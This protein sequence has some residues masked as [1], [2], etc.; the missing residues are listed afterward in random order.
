[1]SAPTCLAS[2]FR[3]LGL[4]P[5]LIVALTFRARSM[6]EF[7]QT[8]HSTPPTTDRFGS[9]SLPAYNHWSNVFLLTP[10]VFA[11]CAVLYPSIL[12]IGIL[13]IR[14][15]SSPFN[16]ETRG[17]L[18]ACITNALHGVLQALSF[19]ILKSVRAVKIGVG[20]HVQMQSQCRRDTGGI[21]VGERWMSSAIV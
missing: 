4:G 8:R 18:H 21:S 12:V 2:Y 1:V 11:A 13:E 16:L 3:F 14:A 17:V 6:S 20:K 10:I 7:D 19:K 15:M 9:S 5:R